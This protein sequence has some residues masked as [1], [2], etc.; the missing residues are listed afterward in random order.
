MFVTEDDF[1]VIPYNIPNLDKVSDTFSSYVD[2]QEA[3]VLKKLLGYKLY[4]EF[5]AGL[6][7]LPTPDAK[8]TDLK[9]GK[10]YDYLDVTYKW[11]GMVALLRPFIYSIWLRDTFDN[12]S[13]AGI[14]ISAPENSEVISP[15]TRIVRAQ[16]QFCMTAGINYRYNG[17]LDWFQDF[18]VSNI[19]GIAMRNTLFGFLKVNIADYPDLAYQA[20]VPMNFFDF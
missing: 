3:I 15:L 1:N 14:V 11:D 20:P 13:G 7:V 6:A 17:Y 19:Y 4:T 18:E 8:W 9:N 12:H 16:N 10:E 2:E 5:I